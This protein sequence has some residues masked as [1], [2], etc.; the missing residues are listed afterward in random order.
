M[1]RT[2][3]VRTGGLVLL[4][5]LASGAFAQEGST[6]SS[7]DI[8]HLGGSTAFYKPSL[9]TVASLNRMGGDPRVV[10]D[11]LTV[12]NQAGAPGLTDRIVAS[13]TGATTTFRGG[14][15]REATPADGTIVEC[16]V[17]PGQELRWMAYRPTGGTSLGVMTNIRWARRDRSLRSSSASPPTTAPIRSS[18]RRSAA[19]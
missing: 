18:C 7:R 15:C 8:T 4:L 6:A 11:V 17:Q 14:L 3:A 19:I 9:T 16:D 1:L 12:L 13:L 5:A 10:A 2:L